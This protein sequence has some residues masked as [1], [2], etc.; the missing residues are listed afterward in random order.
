MEK[1]CF[2][3]LLLLTC[4]FYFSYMSWNNLP[5]GG[6]EHHGLEPLTL[7]INQ[8]NTVLAYLEA[9]LTE[10]FSQLGLPSLR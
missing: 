7:I 2:T 1:H 3:D 4:L 10:V 8:E 9:N 5:V 6:I